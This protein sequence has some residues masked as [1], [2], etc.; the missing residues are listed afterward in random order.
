MRVDVTERCRNVFACSG[1]R[2]SCEQGL[3]GGRIVPLEPDSTVHERTI[4]CV[5]GVGASVQQ[6][7]TP[8]SHHGNMRAHFLRLAF[9]AMLV[10]V[11]AQTMT[12]E[13]AQTAVNL[14]VSGCRTQATQY[15]TFSSS[16]DSTCASTFLD[17]F[18]TAYATNPSLA[19]YYFC[20]TS[21]LTSVSTCAEL[22]SAASSKCDD[23]EAT[24]PGTFPPS[25]PDSAGGA[26]ADATTASDATTAQVIVDP[27][28]T[29]I[30]RAGGV[31]NVGG[32]A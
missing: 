14:L 22:S 19:Q 24:C 28:A 2:Q 15:G 16:L 27:G 21:P 17:G 31:L 29:I 7:A 6:P 9:V 30:V 18:N 11:P 25:P 26:N 23:I 4:A 10:N 8:T 32:A 12:Y 3:L 20:S 13:A 5:H 1:R